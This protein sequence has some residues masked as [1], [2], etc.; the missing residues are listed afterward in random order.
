M[1]YTCPHCQ[2]PLEQAEVDTLSFNVCAQCRGVWM[3]QMRLA[4]WLDSSP[5]TVA[6]LDVAYPVQLNPEVFAGLTMNCPECRT[7]A[8]QAGSAPGPSGS[9]APLC[10]KCGGIWLEAGTRAIVASTANRPD[11]AGP[12][13]GG[14]STLP[15][16]S[17]PVT[18]GT[19]QPGPTLST[20][21]LTR[22]MEG[23]L[24][25]ASGN[26][27]RRPM[28][29]AELARINEAERPF[30][31]VIACASA[32]VSPE[33]IL[34]TALGEIFVLREPGLLV[35]EDILMTCD[36]IM[37]ELDLGLILVMAHSQCSATG[38][39]ASGSPAG[40]P[41]EG[42]Y[43]PL[44]DAVACARRE[45]GDVVDNASKRLAL[46]LANNLRNRR[47]LRSAV[48]SGRLAV[49]TAF[50][51]MTTG[52]VELIDDDPVLAGQADPPPSLVTTPVSQPSATGSLA[53]ADQPSGPMADVFMGSG[54][55]VDLTQPEQA[56][57][58]KRKRMDRKWCPECR[59]AFSAATTFCTNCGVGLVNGKHVVNCLKCHATS[60]IEE[61]SCHECRAPL[62]P[63]WLKARRKTADQIAAMLG[64]GA[65]KRTGSSCAGA[66]GLA[67]LLLTTAAVLL[68]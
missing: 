52:L 43:R 51:D 26:P 8:L 38:I 47:S 41:V 54:P 33:I 59:G 62:H 20:D 3:P 46:G 60:A 10:N 65:G 57:P 42:H 19:L 56:T 18:P 61:D 58:P 39:A 37:E 27:L 2:L 25:Y 24:R 68:G 34:D 64:A 28:T 9:S 13:P 21:P 17:S 1:P 15:P 31:M 45:Q 36:G 66:I 53:S 55:A 5:A 30:A 12:V 7:S 11:V 29:P 6:R 16:A 14:G 63:E 40:T 50:Y 48:A 44:L 4:E 22:L 49:R 23:N 32:R 67:L 35:D